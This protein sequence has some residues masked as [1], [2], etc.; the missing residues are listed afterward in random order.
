MREVPAAEWD[1]VLAKLGLA[2]P[3]YLRAYVEASSIVEPGEPVLLHHDV[4]AMALILR[5]IPGS[6]RRDVITPY[7]YGGPVGPGLNDF[8]DEYG[9]LV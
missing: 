8:Y 3:Y 7:G 9:Y 6:D 5:D 2:D 4:A 1:A